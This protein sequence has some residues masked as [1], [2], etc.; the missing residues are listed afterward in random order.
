MQRLVV[1]DGELGRGCLLDAYVLLRG[2]ELE[3]GVS[4]DAQRGLGVDVQE[5]VFYLIAVGAGNCEIRLVFG[6]FSHVTDAEATDVVIAAARDKNS[7][8]VS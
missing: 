1:I 5:L 6:F 7:V 2:L 4:V 8:K 3:R